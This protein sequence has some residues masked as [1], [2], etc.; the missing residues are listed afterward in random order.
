MLRSPNSIQVEKNY[1]SGGVVAS[2]S[3][4]DARTAHIAL[5]HDAGHASF[6]DLPIAVGQTSRSARVL[7]DPLS[8]AFSRRPARLWRLAA[9][10]AGVN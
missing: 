8:P 4:K 5:Y 6:L 1:N 7:Q 3:G 2:E 9:A 10:E